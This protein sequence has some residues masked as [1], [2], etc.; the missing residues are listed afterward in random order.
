MMN[1]EIIKLNRS[2]GHRPIGE[3]YFSAVLSSQ[4]LWAPR[5]HSFVSF[6]VH[7]GDSVCAPLQGT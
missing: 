3:A 4:C 1:P 5:V 6:A 2:E 7:Q